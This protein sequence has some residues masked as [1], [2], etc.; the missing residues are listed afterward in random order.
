[1]DF[2]PCHQ[3]CFRVCDAFHIHIVRFW[4]IWKGDFKEESAK[5]FPNQNFIHDGVISKR[6]TNN[7]FLS[8]T[9]W[10]IYVYY[11]WKLPAIIRKRWRS[12]SVQSKIK[13][14]L[15]WSI[16]VPIW[17]HGSWETGNLSL[18]SHHMSLYIALLTNV[19][20]SHVRV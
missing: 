1:M 6:F 13:R 7:I 14:D 12:N 9:Y 10:F 15:D 16:C 3:K 11:S 19:Y 4:E 2:L 5:I 20:V 17:I 18:K 8:I